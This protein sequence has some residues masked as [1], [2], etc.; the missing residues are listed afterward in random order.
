MSSKFSWA[1]QG[2]SVWRAKLG[3]FA[4]AMRVFGVR[5]RDID[6]FKDAFGTRW[7]YHLKGPLTQHTLGDQQTLYALCRTALTLVADHYWK[8]VEDVARKSVREI[9]R[10]DGKGRLP[11]ALSGAHARRNNRIVN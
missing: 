3:E 10:M 6:G 5:I 4:K 8:R 9:L 1:S 11:A 2:A 7:A